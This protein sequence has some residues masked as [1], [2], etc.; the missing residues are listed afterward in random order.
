M[1]IDT[2]LAGPLA[3]FIELNQLMTS[4]PCN[5]DCVMCSYHCYMFV[6][7]EHLFIC[8]LNAYSPIKNDACMYLFICTPASHN[9]SQQSSTIHW[10]IN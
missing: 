9:S 7:F 10:L 5:T 1:Y 8:L 6:S 2:Y 3:N 4:P